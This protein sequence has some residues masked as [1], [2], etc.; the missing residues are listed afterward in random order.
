[1]Q[2]ISNSSMNKMTNPAWGIVLY[3]LDRSSFKALVD[4]KSWKIGTLQVNKNTHY[5]I[6]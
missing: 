5:N 2:V 1:M 3:S 4:N 6:L